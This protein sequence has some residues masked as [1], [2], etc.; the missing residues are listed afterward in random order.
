MDIL[1]KYRGIENFR[2]FVDIVLKNRLYASKY[3][4]MNDPME[5]QYVYP[6]GELDREILNRI[7]SEKNNLRICSLSNSKDNEL[8]W[9]HYSEGHRG[10]LIGLKVDRSNYDVQSIQ[11]DGLIS[12]QRHEVGNNTARDIL[13]RKLNVWGYE[14][15]VRV[16]VSNNN[17]VDIEIKEIITGR[18]M[19]NQNYNFIKD[20][21]ETINP[22]IKV[23]K[24]ATFM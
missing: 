17:Y 3:K 14:E 23:I 8:M 12:L 20:L 5:G 19:S 6:Q 1:Y 15:E 16:F 24:A 2:F 13:L 22:D 4:D 10:V 11:Y 21:V 9:S 18:K 7:Y